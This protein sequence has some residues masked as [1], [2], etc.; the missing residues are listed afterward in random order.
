MKLF[1]MAKT[2]TKLSAV[3]GRK[4]EHKNLTR[5]IL[6]TDLHCFCPLSYS[7]A[8]DMAPWQPGGYALK[9]S[10]GP[11]SGVHSTAN[12][13]NLT[14]TTTAHNGKFTSD[15]NF[16]PFSA[17]RSEMR[18]PED[19][20]DEF[21]M[22]SSRSKRQSIS[23]LQNSGAASCQQSFGRCR[24]FSRL[25]S[26]MKNENNCRSFIRSEYFYCA[27]SN[28]LLFKGAPTAAFDTVPELTCRSATGS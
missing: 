3:P 25:S 12:N 17:P 5:V 8:A 28:P 6:I 16:F 9:E 7:A 20:D 10:S 22:L 27:S 1:L 21:D 4:K 13:G 2:M 24:V 19:V 26:L 11:L 15:D 18:K 23:G 14:T